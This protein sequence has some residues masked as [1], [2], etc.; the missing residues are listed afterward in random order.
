MGRGRT[1][2]DAPEANTSFTAWCPGAS[3]VWRRL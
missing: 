3:H 1:Q 2:V